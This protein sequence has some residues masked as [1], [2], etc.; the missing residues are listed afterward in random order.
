LA[1]S[2]GERGLVEEWRWWW[3]RGGRRCG[4]FGMKVRVR[5]R[6]VV[7]ACVGFIMMFVPM[8]RDCR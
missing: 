7:V 4:L 1:E 6:W 3:W 2:G 5:V 8:R